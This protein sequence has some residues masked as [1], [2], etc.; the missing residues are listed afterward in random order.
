MKSW[1]FNGD[2]PKIFDK[3]V[4]KSV[5]LYNEIQNL[6]INLGEFFIKDNSNILD[7]GCSTGTTII[8]LINNI[9]KNF[10]ITG[11][12]VSKEMIETAEDNIKSINKVTKITLLNDS[13]LN[14]N[15]ENLDYVISNL[16]LQFLNLSDK[17]ILCKNIYNGLNKGGALIVFEKVYSKEPMYQDIYNQLYYDFKEDKGFTDEE[18]RKKE[19][20]LRGILRPMKD[21]DNL[22]LL[23]SCGFMVEE[24]FRYLNFIG[25]LCIKG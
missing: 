21:K 2:I 18:I 8:N 22:E 1:N 17:E 6:I 12:D 14:I 23:K 5:P 20:S 11:V 13:I 24:C 4:E 3:H 7:I 9:E 16:T 10:Y 25:Y 15:M 19:K